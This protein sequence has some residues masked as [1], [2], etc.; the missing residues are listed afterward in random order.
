MRTESASFGHTRAGVPVEIHTLENRSGLRARISSYGA[1]L[2]ELLVPDR[3]GAR[4][5]VVQGFDTLAG[6]ESPANR[7]FGCTVGR[8][9]NRIAGA[10][11]VLDGEVVRL[12]ANEGRHHLHGGRSGLDKQVWN[13]SVSTEPTASVRFEHESPDGH[14]GYPGRLLV[15][16]TY[17]LTETDELQLDYEA[18]TNRPTPVNL[19]HHSY[20]NLGARTGAR[21]GDHLLWIGAQHY[22]PTD[23]ERIP[24]GAIEPV[25][26]TPL[27]FTTPRPVALGGM[28]YDHNFVLD[29]GRGELALAARLTDPGSERSLEILTTEPGL[30]LYVTADALCLETQRFP[31]AVHHPGFPTVILRPGETY[32]Q[33]TI[34]RFLAG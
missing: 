1:T 23:D 15:S 9:A 12:T 18:Q 20:F 7:Y 26:D 31:D 32:Q 13:A 3:R 28:V 5:N 14:E 29:E 22:T 11:F 17:T 34:Y 8:C 24:T 2:V 6:Y 33:R 25:A 10:E 27:D 21:I 16:V 30:Q 4:A 19:T